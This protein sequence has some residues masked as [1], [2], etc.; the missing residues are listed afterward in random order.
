[1]VTLVAIIDDLVGPLEFDDAGFADGSLSLKRS[2][3]QIE[4]DFFGGPIDDSA[5]REA[6]RLLG[7]FTDLEATL[8]VVLDSDEDAVPLFVSHHLEHLSPAAMKAAL[9]TETGDATKILAALV[10]RRIEI[11]P[12]D[13]EP[14]QCE[15]G[16]PASVSDY[17]LCVGIDRSGGITDVEMES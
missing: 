9:G 2:T 1:M 6:T 15:F 8:R 14:L 12:S 17:V 16:L 5:L 13:E 7:G 4:V 10:L 11:R 3:V